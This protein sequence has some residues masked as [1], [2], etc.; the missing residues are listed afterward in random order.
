[1]TLANTNEVDL[2][3][4]KRWA[5]PLDKN[6]AR[7]MTENLTQLLGTKRIEKYP[8]SH[9]TAV[10]YQVSVDLQR[11]DTASDG[12]SRLVAP[13]TIKDGRNGKDIYASETT[14]SDPV[15]SAETGPS[16]A[17]SNDLATLSVDIANRI[18]MMSETQQTGPSSHETSIPRALRTGSLVWVG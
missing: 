16:I 7:I 17:M 8:W 14:A 5:E 4:D 10:D 12:Q 3:D 13:W 1:M 18:A 2:S 15:R 9:K 11:F 6:F